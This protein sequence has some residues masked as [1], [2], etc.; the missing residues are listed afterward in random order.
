[1]DIVLPSAAKP[2]MDAYEKCVFGSEDAILHITGLDRKILA[3]RCFDSEIA[4]FLP[5]VQDERCYCDPE[6]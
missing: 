1:M 5:H 3:R 6:A 2:H 4:F